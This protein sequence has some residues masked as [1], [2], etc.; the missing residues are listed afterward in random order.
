MALGK[1]LEFH[2]KF[3]SLT[4]VVVTISFD[5]EEYPTFDNDVRKELGGLDQLFMSTSKFPRLHTVTVVLKVYM[6]DL[7][8]EVTRLWVGNPEKIK[9]FLPHFAVRLGCTLLP[10]VRLA[11]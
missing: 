8:K 1:A 5:W 3:P 4:T 2:H 10:L 6:E 11:P 7:L 9:E